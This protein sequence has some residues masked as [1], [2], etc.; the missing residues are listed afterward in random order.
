MTF[1]ADSV[2]YWTRDGVETVFFANAEKELALTLSNVPG[3]ADHYV[4]WNDQS[5][6]CANGVKSVLLSGRN[7]KVQ[8]TAKAAKLL[9]EPQFQVA[10]NCTDTDL[11]EISNRLRLI[12]GRKFTSKQPA[13]PA[14]KAPPQ[15]DY[16]RIKYLNLEWKNLKTLP[17]HVK[18]LTSLETAKLA[19]N[20]RLDFYE[21]CEVL[22]QFPSLKQLSFTTDG[23]VPGNIGKLSSL[24]SLSLDGFKTPQRLPETF[25]QLTKLKYLLIMS[26]SEV[27]LPESLAG[28]TELCQLN[29]RAKRWRMPSE[30]H[31]LSK[32]TILDFGS[33][34]LERVPEEM[35]GMTAV[36]AIYL[37]GLDHDLTQILPIVARMPNLEQLEISAN[38]IPREIGLCRQI[39]ELN[40]WTGVGSQTPLQL[41]DELFDLTQLKT[42]ILSLNK[43]DRIPEAIGRLKGLE[44]LV[45]IESDFEALPE[46]LGE[47][48]NLKL[49]NVSENPSFQKLP[50]TVGNLTELRRL[51]LADNPY[52]QR[53]PDSLRNLT[54]L[55]H[56]QITDSHRVENIP[57]ALK[58]ILMD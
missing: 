20:P 11:T 10:L 43:F 50:E 53:L 30:F 28:L 34:Q 27:I 40:I 33:C 1:Q 54:K 57:P 16:S 25:D 12:V 9:G 21:V 32:L 44:Q 39:D 52:L 22:S 36:T 4:E 46:A 26:D 2:E 8:L 56:V 35:A 29:M 45:F 15:Q 5:N 18:E 58:R 51:F 24:E 6:A 19:G 55:E 31:R 49:L 38:P 3:T 13:S 17:D 48:S 47:L 41:P 23:P 37:T 14:K 42:L 7:L